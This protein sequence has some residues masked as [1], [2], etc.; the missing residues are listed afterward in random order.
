[1]PVERISPYPD[2]EATQLHLDEMLWNI[3]SQLPPSNVVD[4]GMFPP[5]V[6]GTVGEMNIGLTINTWAGSD[7]SNLQRD[8][9][10]ARSGGA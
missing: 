5:D 10:S 2:E 4:E 1:M 9:S 8:A 6:S 3:N 7:Q